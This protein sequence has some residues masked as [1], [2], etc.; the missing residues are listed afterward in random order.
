MT[1]AEKARDTAYTGAAK[2][3]G[4]DG[5]VRIAVKHALAQLPKETRAVAKG[6]GGSAYNLTPKEALKAGITKGAIER[7]AAGR[8]LTPKQ[9]RTPGVS[10]VLGA[11]AAVARLTGKASGTVV[12][13]RKNPSDMPIPTDLAGAQKLMAGVLKLPF[14]TNLAEVR[15]QLPTLQKLMKVEARPVLPT[16]RPDAMAPPSAQI[17]ARD[18]HAAMMQA[19][20]DK[21]APQL[22]RALATRDANQVKFGTQAV[23]AALGSIGPSIKQN[24]GA[25]SFIPGVHNEN[26]VPA[27][28]RH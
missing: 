16:H 25:M 1:V 20:L 3:Y 28:P 2:L 12:V 8:G 14:Q 26:P 13:A 7:Q 4:S 9:M 10:S 6:K 15:K 24:G 19:Q 5:A 18:Q 17:A 21:N 23:G 27:S 11:G 22:D